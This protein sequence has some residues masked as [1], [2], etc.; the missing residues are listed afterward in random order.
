MHVHTGTGKTNLQTLMCSCFSVSW[1]S[2]R[3]KKC[4]QLP[5]ARKKHAFCSATQRVFSTL[6]ASACFSSRPPGWSVS[7]W[8]RATAGDGRRAFLL[9]VQMMSSACVWPCEHWPR[10]VD[11]AFTA[12]RIVM[13]VSLWRISDAIL[14]CFLTHAQWILARASVPFMSGR[15]FVAA[16]HVRGGRARIRLKNLIRISESLVESSVIDHTICNQVGGGA[17]GFPDIWGADCNDI[18]A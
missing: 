9:T 6:T 13:T 5:P 1:E 18:I 2:M 10:I 15:S 11:T 12:K 3:R 7:Q 16:L 17:G 8:T 14:N 4:V